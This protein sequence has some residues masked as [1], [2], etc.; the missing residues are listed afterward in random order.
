MRWT[1]VHEGRECSFSSKKIF[2][3]CISVDF[4]GCSCACTSWTVT[5]QGLHN[6]APLVWESSTAHTSAGVQRG[7]H[8][9][10]A[11]LEMLLKDCAALEFVFKL[12]PN[13]SLNQ[14]TIKMKFL[15]PSWDVRESFSSFSTDLGPS[16][17]T[18]KCK[19]HPL[20]TVKQ[21]FYTASFS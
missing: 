12:T 13:P 19:C 21:L 2:S 18:A 15:V 16:R 6:K 17:G 8:S 5:W 11:P 10:P 14:Y 1:V 3:I 9:V 7:I 4:P 20:E